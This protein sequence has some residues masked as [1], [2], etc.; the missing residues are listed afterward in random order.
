MRFSIQEDAADW[1]EMRIGS[2]FGEEMDAKDF[3]F[4]H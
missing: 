1:N 2:I 4:K 3:E